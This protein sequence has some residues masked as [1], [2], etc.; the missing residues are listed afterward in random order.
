MSSFSS[1]I[2]VKKTRLINTPTGVHVHRGCTHT[3]VQPCVFEEI[4]TNCERWDAGMLVQYQ[5]CAESSCQRE[6][7]CQRSRL[8]HYHPT[9]TPTPTSSTHDCVSY[10]HNHIHN[11]TCTPFTQDQFET[12]QTVNKHLLPPSY[13]QPCTRAHGH[14]LRFSALRMG[15]H[16]TKVKQNEVNTRMPCHTFKGVLARHAGAS[17]FLH[18]RRTRAEHL[19]TIDDTARH[20]E[21]NLLTSGTLR[22]MIAKVARRVLTQQN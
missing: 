7:F 13:E 16:C 11:I 22:G 12:K 6:F 1:S 20:L 15:E 4:Q 3:I 9:P 2:P 19:A 10:P 5:C 21:R 18:T 14:G 17:E 8:D